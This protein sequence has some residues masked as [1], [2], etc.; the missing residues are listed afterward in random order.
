MVQDGFSEYAEARW[1]TLV[2]SAVLLGCDLHEAEDLAQA[3]LLRCYVKWAQVERAADRDAYVA[4]ILVNLHRQSRRRR[5]WREQPTQVLPEEAVGDRTGDVDGTETVRLALAGLS[6]EHREVVLLRV[7]LQLS[8]R[9]T[10]DALRIAPGTVKSRL[11]RALARLAGDPD[12]I[13]LHG[14]TRGEP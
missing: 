11:S 3:T 6:V 14:Q 8:E 2:R 9:Q 7:H 4:R 12:L 1:R 5:W 10:A 13:D